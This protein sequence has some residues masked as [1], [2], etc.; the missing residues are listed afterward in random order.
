MQT[1]TQQAAMVGATAR[2]FIP[3]VVTKDLAIAHRGEKRRVL[4]SSNFLRMMGFD[5]SVRHNI[6]PI[7]PLDGMRLTCTPD[8][9]H[10]I[11]E[12]SYTKRKNNPF[13]T[14]IDIQNQALIDAAIPSYTERV[15][16]EIRRGEILIRPLANRTFTIRRQFAGAQDFAA[17]VAMTSGID[18]RCLVDCG[19][20]I[21]AVLE[22]RPQEKRDLTDLTET[23]A[24][25][26]LAN[27]SP[28]VLFNEDI[29]RVE[30]SRV[31]R[32][33]GDAPPIALLHLSLQC[34][35][36]SPLKTGKAK[37]GAVASLDTT[38]D[39]V[40]D[41]LRLIETVRP[42]V[43][44]VEQVPG[45]ASSPEGR[46]LTIK[47]R[48][49]GYHVT[50][51]VLDA[52]D[53]GGLTSRSRY[54]L[55]ASVWP[56]FDMPPAQPRPADPIWPLIARHLHQCRDVS[57]TNTVAEGLATGRIRLI[58]QRSTC[59]P[60]ITK[61]QNRQCKDSVYIEH[62]GRYLLPTT[63][64]LAELNGIP[65]DL[66]FDCVADTIASEIIGQSIDVPMHEGVVRAVR[67]H[68]ATNAAGA[69]V[70]S[71]GRAS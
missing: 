23:G 6:E 54:Y 44:M 48:K 67:S 8:G 29:S 62:E 3:K 71:V 50:G 53:H 63:A 34:D 58:N 60:T 16:F 25:N 36:F 47:L 64:L 45:F 41:G 52:R 27:A 24:L 49:W 9:S 69:A 1:L 15:H 19:F 43:V 26:V 65:S 7:A 18:T 13:E 21:D 11:Y 66:S 51:A 10:K 33:M 39:L 68:I 32:L 12:R 17:F 35:D 59:A 2:A 55:V 56:G 28:R 22:Y 57:H 4:L 46:L 61:S 5:A 20:K 40:Y 31:E 30:M 14:Q 38:A 37:A 42:A 70:I